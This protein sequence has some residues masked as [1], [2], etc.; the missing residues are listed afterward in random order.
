VKI[1]LQKTFQYTPIFKKERKKAQVSA[2]KVMDIV[3]YCSIIGALSAEVSAACRSW[4][5]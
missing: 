3:I 1:Q 2:K 4:R 5:P